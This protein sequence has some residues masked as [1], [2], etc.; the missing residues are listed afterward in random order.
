MDK[1]PIKV[2]SSESKEV[3]LASIE[4]A[5]FWPQ[6]K[7][8]GEKGLTEAAE[9]QKKSVVM[10]FYG[11]LGELRRRIIACLICLLAAT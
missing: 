9:G 10:D 11:H 4:N 6:S 8:E 7:S 3:S 2:N 1:A 5:N